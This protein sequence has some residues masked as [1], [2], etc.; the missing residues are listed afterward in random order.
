LPLKISH[1]TTIF[2]KPLLR[3]GIE[4]WRRRTAERSAE[5]ICRPRN[6]FVCEGPCDDYAAGVPIDIL[7]Y[8]WIFHM[9]RRVRQQIQVLLADLVEVSSALNYRVLR[10]NQGVTVDVL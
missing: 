7:S 9:L 2:L 6:T 10:R 8:R 3:G 1:R 5:S 4:D